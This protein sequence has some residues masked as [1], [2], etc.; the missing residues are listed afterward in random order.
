MDGYIYIIDCLRQ[1]VAFAP[2][3]MKCA[4]GAIKGNKMRRLRRRTRKGVEVWVY[5][6]VEEWVRAP[7]YFINSGLIPDRRR[8]CT[9]LY[10]LRVGYL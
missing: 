6:W 10:Y 3:V 7:F 1:V 5:G 9:Y 8:Y 2:E 4:Y